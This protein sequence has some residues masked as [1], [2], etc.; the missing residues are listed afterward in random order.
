[1]TESKKARRKRADDL[2]KRIRA[3][4]A[5]AES[6]ADDTPEIKPDESPNEYVERRM[7]ELDRAKDPTREDTSRED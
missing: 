6:P 5:A 7:K 1:M 3:L 4:Q 2:R